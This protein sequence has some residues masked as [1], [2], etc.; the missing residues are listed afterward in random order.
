MEWFKAAEGNTL[1]VNTIQHHV[2][3]SH[4]D[5]T[6]ALTCRI[7]GSGR[8]NCFHCREDR[9]KSSPL[10]RYDRHK[11]HDFRI[12]AATVGHRREQGNVTEYRRSESSLCNLEGSGNPRPVCFSSYSCEEIQTALIKNAVAIFGSSLSI[13][14]ELIRIEVL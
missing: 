9:S 3:V 14:I 10:R 7:S 4:L 5:S 6:P 12:A 1:C 2:V 8:S 11:C 13:F